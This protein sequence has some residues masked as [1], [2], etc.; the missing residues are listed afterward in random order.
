MANKPNDTPPKTESEAADTGP[1][2]V[3]IANPKI[4]STEHT[5]AGETAAIDVAPDT[6]ENSL[7][8]RRGGIIGVV[9]GTAVAVILIFGL[10]VGSWPYWSPQLAALIPAPQQDVAE[11]ER[12]DTLEG[13]IGAAEAGLA[14]TAAQVAEHKQ[15]VVAELKALQA[16]RQAVGKQLD[17]AT[18]RLADVEQSLAV[19]RETATNGGVVDDGAGLSAMDTRIAALEQ[20]GAST[21][22]LRQRLD[23]LAARMAVEETRDAAIADLARRNQELADAVGALTGRLSDVEAARASAGDAADAGADANLLVAIADLR[24]VLGTSRAFEEAL[25]AVV[26]AADGEADLEAVVLPLRPLAAKGIPTRDHLRSRFAAVAQAMVNADAASGG[27]GWFDQ[28]ANRLRGLITIRRVGGGPSRTDVDAAV[29][30]AETALAAGELAA[31]VASLENLS[32][33]AADT[34]ADWLSDARGRLAAEQV[35][36]TL[37]GRAARASAGTS[38][39]N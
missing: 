13:R 33:P 2:D 5:G 6:K 28:T 9:I 11:A 30:H 19:L 34:A 23:A 37:D 12:L 21:D 20:A 24:R 15:D 4:D 36:A 35:L 7:P 17:A 27:D 22:Q 16:A 38:G 32:G 3:E 26:Q 8:P 25:S 18:A 31:A 10:A 1:S 14:G 29:S 39:G